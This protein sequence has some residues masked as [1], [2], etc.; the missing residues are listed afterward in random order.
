MLNV[1]LMRSNE[2]SLFEQTRS[3]LSE[4]KDS[5]FTLVVDEL[6]AYRGTTGSEVAVTIRNFLDR[7]GLD[8]QS[9]QLRIIATSASIT[10]DSKGK[11]KEFVERFFGVDSKKFKFISGN[12]KTNFSNDKH[13]E[14]CILGDA[15]NE[16][17]KIH[18]EVDRP[19]DLGEVLNIL[20]TKYQV[21]EPDAFLTKIISSAGR[22]YINPVPNFRI[23]NFLRQVEAIWC[24]SNPVCTEV[25][26]QYKFEGRRF[27]RLFST[28]ALQCKCGSRVVELLYCYDCGELF[29]GG[30]TVGLEGVWKSFLHQLVAMPR[31]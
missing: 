7:I 6:H 25:E 30:H 27:G 22:D 9:D 1:M 11:G 19:Q 14:Q 18:N 20:K 31:Q 3:W 21:D 13:R 23:H 10:D 2:D 17:S 12:P 28:P 24:C 4:N 16:V 29:L 8:G 5:Q 26:N 15:I